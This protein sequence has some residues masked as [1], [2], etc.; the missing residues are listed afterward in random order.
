M[1]RH[2]MHT[3][4]QKRAKGQAA[5]PAADT[6]DTGVGWDHTSAPHELAVSEPIPATDA[7]THVPLG[8]KVLSAFGD[9]RVGVLELSELARL[10]DASAQDIAVTVDTL[11]ASGDLLRGVDGRIRCEPK[12]KA[13]LERMF[14]SIAH[15]M[16]DEG[17][18]VRHQ[19]GALVEEDDLDEPRLPITAGL[20]SMFLPG[21]GQ[22][23]NGDVG[24][25]SLVFAVWSL[26]WITHLSPVWTFVIL[27]AG[28]EAFLTAKVRGLERKVAR[29]EARQK[30]ALPVA[31][32]PRKPEPA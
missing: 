29:E 31:G 25:A 24:R 23:L 8:M 3:Q 16:Q 13:A 11:V 32:R 28:A 4:R 17:A 15:E 12:R 19:S 6:P 21:T 14:R 27:Y 20:L 30:A 18:L 1:R 26:A 5:L 2:R 7:A 9:P 22:L 10:V